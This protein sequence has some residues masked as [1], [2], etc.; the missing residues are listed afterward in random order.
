MPFLEYQ[1]TIKIIFL[2]Q[3]KWR[4]FVWISLGCYKILADWADFFEDRLLLDMGN[5][6]DC[7]S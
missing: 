3:R 2:R 1:V 7:I 4:D 6:L 5:K